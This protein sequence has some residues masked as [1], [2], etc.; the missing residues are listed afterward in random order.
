MGLVQSAFHVISNLP[1]TLGVL[2]SVIH[3]LYNVKKLRLRDVKS[4][5]ESHTAG[6]GRGLTSTMTVGQPC[7]VRES[8]FD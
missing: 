7:I 3:H 6:Q 2:P 8:M 1:T 4:L 5:V